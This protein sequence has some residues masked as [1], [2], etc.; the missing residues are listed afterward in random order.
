[1]RDEQRIFAPFFTVALLAKVRAHPRQLRPSGARVLAGESALSG[2]ASTSPITWWIRS[3]L[4]TWVATRICRHARSSSAWVIGL[5]LP[6][7]GTV[8][9]GLTIRRW[10]DMAAAVRLA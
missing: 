8:P 2:L 1:M 3:G 9:S 6:G 5:R 4:R 10:Q 7:H